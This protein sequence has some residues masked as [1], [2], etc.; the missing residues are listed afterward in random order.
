MAS[1]MLSPSAAALTEGDTSMRINDGKMKAAAAKASAQRSRSDM[2]QI[3][4]TA[5]EFEAT[6]LS[7]MMQDMFEGVGD[8]EFFGK[9]YAN[10]VYKSMLVD[11]YGKLLAKSGGVGIADHVKRELLTL[12]EVE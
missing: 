11:E 4:K 7:Q 1:S 9:S 2:A 6:F 8:D 3:D 10:D 5:Q 12:Q